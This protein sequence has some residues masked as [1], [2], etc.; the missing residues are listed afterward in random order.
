MRVRTPLILTVATA[1]L[2]AGALP[3]SADLTGNTTVT[4]G[5]TGGSLALAVESAAP[6]WDNGVTTPDGVVVTGSLGP[7]TVTDATA[8]ATGWTASAAATNFRNNATPPVSAGA[9][10]YDLLTAD[11]SHTG[12][13]TAT[14]AHDQTPLP[15]TSVPIVTGASASGGNSAT[16]SPNLS[17]TVPAAALAANTYT[18]T[19]ATS[20]L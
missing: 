17:V 4:F 5:L 8:D 18:G 2:V 1:A 16:W 7:V 13:V 3:A 12:V 20:V 14:A 9:I 6:G 10:T 11:I 19:V 15:A